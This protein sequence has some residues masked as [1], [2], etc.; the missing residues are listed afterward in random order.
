MGCPLPVIQK[1]L[2]HTSLEMTQRYS[3]LQEQ[4][5]RAELEKLGGI[6]AGQSFTGQKTGRSDDFEKMPVAGSA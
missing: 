6:F 1:H 2:E 3:H 5:E 4:T